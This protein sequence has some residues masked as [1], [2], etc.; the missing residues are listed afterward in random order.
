MLLTPGNRG[1]AVFAAFLRDVL[2][3]QVAEGGFFVA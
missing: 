3:K 2:K 1:F